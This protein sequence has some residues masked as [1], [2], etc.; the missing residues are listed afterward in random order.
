[1]TYSLL[2]YTPYIIAGIVFVCVMQ[3]LQDRDMF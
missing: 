3:L 1:M 2:D